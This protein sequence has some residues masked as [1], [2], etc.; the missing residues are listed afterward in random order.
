MEKTQ[1]QLV[2]FQVEYAGFWVRLL[3]TLVD[4][5]LL[6]VFV[7]LPLTL[8]YGPQDYFL[9]EQIFLGFWNVVLGYIVPVFVTIWFWIRFLGTPGKILLKLQVVDATS[10]GAITGWQ[11][12]GRYVGYVISIV[13]LLLGFFWI[14][15]D[16]RKQGW[17]DKLAGTLVIKKQSPIGPEPEDLSG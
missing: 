1:T 16:E 17:H 15:F 5:M 13:V 7:T 3:A 2:D 4:T 8:V 10:M 12:I 11:A 6:T 14:A 9:S